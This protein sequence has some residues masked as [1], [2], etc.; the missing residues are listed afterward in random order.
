MT[1]APSLIC[2]DLG[3]VFIRLQPD[4]ASACRDAGVEFR[5]GWEHLASDA[6]RLELIER[7]QVGAIDCETYYRAMSD[8]SSGRYTPDE[9]EAIHR[10]WVIEPYA[11][12][13]A[14]LDE[15]ESS[16]LATACLSN[17]NASHWRWLEGVAAF[18][19]LKHRHA[20][21]LLG[22]HKPDERIYRAFEREVDRRGG[23]IVLFDDL[24]ENVEAARRLGWQAHRIDPAGDTVAQMRRVLSA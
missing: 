13:D 14:L 21:H 4:L 2:F 19:R 9:I 5:G 22:F 6:P 16:D 7:Y 18:N 8:L 12:I 15:I 11:G 1:S 17:T 24:P 20:S 3:G 23:E 10:V